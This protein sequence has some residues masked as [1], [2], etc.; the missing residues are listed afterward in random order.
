[1]QMRGAMQGIHNSLMKLTYK[2]IYVPVVII[3]EFNIQRG[4]T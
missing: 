2:F 4:V 1:M 3:N